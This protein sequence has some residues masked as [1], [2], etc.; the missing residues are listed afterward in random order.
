VERVVRREAHAKI[1]RWLRVLGRRPDGY[2]EIDSLVVPVSLTDEV[3]VRSAPEF[4]LSVRGELADNVP[5]DEDNLVVR[6]ARAL[7]QA[8][9][10]DAAAEIE[11]TKRIPIAAGLGGGSADAAATLLALDE[12]WG[13]SIDGDALMA[14]GAEVGSDVPA[15][16]HGGAVRIR[17]RG[18]I[19]EPA[20]GG[21]LWLVLVPQDFGV[22]VGD[23]YG[24]WEED[25]SAAAGDGT[26]ND[27]E[28][29]VLARYPEVVAARDRLVAEG[30]IETIM[31]GSGPTMAGFARS[32][33]D[34]RR[35]AEAVPG[36]IPVAAP[37]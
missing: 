3:T 24:W 4:R 6:A 23:A 27:L 35:I 37:P 29:P 18:E 28:A 15:L 21:E 2:H 9:D 17:G 34:A 5:L 14:I 12:L 33:A 16:L 1:N 22:A 10:T 26:T 31:C 8:L 36:S 7:A 11:L 32:E 13:T 25:G 20:E 30:A 19:V